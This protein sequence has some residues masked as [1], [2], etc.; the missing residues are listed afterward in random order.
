MA[1]HSVRIDFQQA[2]GDLSLDL[3]DTAGTRI[4]RSA[5]SL[6]GEEISLAGLSA[7]VYYARVYGANGAVN[8]HYDL[9]LLL[10][11]VTGGGPDE[12]NDTRATAT[13]LG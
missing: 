7:G 4:G 3:Y 12:P 5:G 6:D 13:D 8:A 1:G 11:R 9:D 2:Q 10:P